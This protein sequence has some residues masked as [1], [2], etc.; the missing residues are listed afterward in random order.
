MS[1]HSNLAHR[2]SR[3][4]RCFICNE[5]I[6]LETAKVDEFGKPVHEECYVQTIGL[7]R[8]I[9]NPPEASDAARTSL[10]QAILTFLTIEE[11]RA[12]ANFCPVCGS[13][14]EHR[15]LIFFFEGKIREIRVAVCLDCDPITD[16][17]PYDA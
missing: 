2:S 8:S 12:V 7:K 17:P 14:L 15:N 13:Q 1:L 5:F 3:L 6:E 16:D 11:A 4:F 9:R 10:S